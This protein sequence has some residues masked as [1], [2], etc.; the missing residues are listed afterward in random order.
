MDQDT[1][2]NPLQNRTAAQHAEAEHVPRPQ[3]VSRPVNQVPVQAPLMNNQLILSKQVI[4]KG[5]VSRSLREL[6]KIDDYFHQAAIRG[7]KDQQLP[8]IGKVLDSL[9]VVNNLNMLKAEDRARL[10]SFLSQVKAKAPVVHMS[11]PSEA[12]GPFLGKIL[13]WFRTDVHPYTVMTIGLQPELV[14]GC[15]VRTTNKTFDFSFRQKFDKSREKLIVALQSKPTA[16]VQ[17]PSPQQSVTE[18][19]QPDMIPTTEQG[20]TS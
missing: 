15:M 17:N 18:N 3:E 12:S 2:L 11:F 13:E 1:N 9:A 7:S 6:E 5:D 20:V 19:I 14:A 8:T 16:S 4:S 10:R